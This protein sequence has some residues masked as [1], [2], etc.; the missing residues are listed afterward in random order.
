[1]DKKICP[2]CKKVIV[3]YPSISRK[4]NKT[5]ICS[6]CGVEEAVNEFINHYK[7]LKN[8]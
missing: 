5:E 7:E 3:G 2:I 4:D 8:G 1:M 6:K